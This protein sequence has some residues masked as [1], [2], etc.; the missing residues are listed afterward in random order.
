MQA[1]L[2]GQLL[3][4]GF[5]R[6]IFSLKNNGL[7]G[8]GVG[9]IGGIV[10]VASG[11]ELP[12]YWHRLARAQIP[13]GWRGECRSTPTATRRDH[14]RQRLQAAGAQRCPRRARLRW[15]K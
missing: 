8:K 11:E 3:G 1:E 9:Q 10:T 2:L 12:L 7:A 5:S 13:L 14:E 4:H 15:V 6:K